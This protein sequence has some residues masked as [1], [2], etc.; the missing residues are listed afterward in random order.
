M[1]PDRGRSRAAVEGEGERSLGRVLAVER[2]GDKEH[3]SFNLA[4]AA[5]DGEASGG[6]G[7]LQGLA[8]HSDLVVGRDGSD[9]GHVKA[10]FFL[11]FIFVVAGLLVR[12]WRGGFGRLGRGLL[13]LFLFGLLGGL[14]GLFFLFLPRRLRLLLIILVGLL[15]GGE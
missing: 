11:F 13:G 4:V 7:V 5:L 9:L 12:L 10:L 2:V 6:R 8:V 14:L 3:F 1:Q 15:R